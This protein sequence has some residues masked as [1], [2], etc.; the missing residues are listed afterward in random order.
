MSSLVISLLI[1]EIVSAREVI[2]HL[3]Q[4]PFTNSKLAVSLKAHK[5]T[6]EEIVKI[7]SEQIIDPLSGY[8]E[9]AKAGRTFE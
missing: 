7:T 1:K 4:T 2:R 3:E 6:C 5:K 8:A 9:Q